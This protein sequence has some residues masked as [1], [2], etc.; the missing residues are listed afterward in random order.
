MFSTAHKSK[1]LEFETVQVMNDFQER[2]GK[3]VR[4]TLSIA[5]LSFCC[6]FSDTD[7]NLL[8]VVVTRATKRLIMSR[9]LV[10]ML[11]EREMVSCYSITLYVV[12]INFFI[13]Q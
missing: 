12:G 2:S 11:D 10:D 13:R 4:F 8:Y 3:F 6:T 5:I 9:Y 1:G 7:R